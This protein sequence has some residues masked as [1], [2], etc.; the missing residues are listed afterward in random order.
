MMLRSSL[1]LLAT[2]LPA[3][4]GCN[5]QLGN[6]EPFIPRGE[7]GSCVRLPLKRRRIPVVAHANFSRSSRTGPELRIPMP[8]L[9]MMVRFSRIL[10]RV[11]ALVGV[12]VLP[13][14]AQQGATLR[15]VVT[16]S[17]LFIFG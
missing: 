16:D 8:T 3:I 10:V 6:L 7:L 15:G 12:A 14:G 1:C 9:V 5:R 11:L 2:L 17:A 13:A 4:A